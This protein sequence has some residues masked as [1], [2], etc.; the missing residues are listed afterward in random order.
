MTKSDKH[1]EITKIRYYF[2]LGFVPDL[3]LKI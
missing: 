1:A 3:N 2:A